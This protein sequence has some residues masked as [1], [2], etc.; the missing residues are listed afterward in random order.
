[1]VSAEYN[2]EKV[3]IKKMENGE[4]AIVE[5]AIMLK[6]TNNTDLERDGGIQE[7][8]FHHGHQA[9]VSW[10]HHQLF[11]S[12]SR[13]HNQQQQWACLVTASMCR[14]CVLD[15]PGVRESV[16]NGPSEK[17]LCSGFA[18]KHCLCAPEIV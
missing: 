13:C 11:Q 15:L 17:T 6:T 1:M 3:A 18:P 2:N 5:M 4:D 8:Q 16:E 10:A 12:Q 9:E 14:I 7:T